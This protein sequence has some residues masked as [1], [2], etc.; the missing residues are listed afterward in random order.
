MA[1]IYF[2][3]LFFGCKPCY[4]TVAVTHGC[5]RIYACKWFYFWH[6]ASTRP[7]QCLGG[8]PGREL[9]PWYSNSNPNNIKYWSGCPHR[10]LD[11]Q[12]HDRSEQLGAD[13]WVPGQSQCGDVRHREADS[14]AHEH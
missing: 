11:G 2:Y 5:L 10:D 6:I 8:A 13:R 1:S 12:Q 9:C 7:S 14:H 3:S 4:S